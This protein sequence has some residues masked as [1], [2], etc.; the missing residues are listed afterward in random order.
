MR[1]QNEMAT[2]ISID[3]VGATHSLKGLSDAVRGATNAWKAQVAYQNSVGNSLGAAKAKYEGLGNAIDQQKSK[4]NELRNRQ[5]E[6]NVTNTE[7]VEKY[8]KY[9]AEIDKLRSEQT[10]LDTSTKEGKDRFAELSR[11][12]DD[13]REAQSKNTGIT[14][15]DAEQYLKLDKQISQ[16]ENQLRSY[17]AQQKRAAET[18]KYYESGLA[19][20]QKSYK[21]NN[22]VSKSFTERLK[23]EGK[24][25]SA[26]VNEYKGLQNSLKNLKSQYDIQE[27]ELGQIETA[28][29]KT[30]DAYKKQEIRL[31]ETGKSIAETESKAKSMRGEF[32]RLQPTGIDRIDKAVVRTRDTT[33]KLADGAKNAFSRFKNAAIGASIGVATLGAGL[34]K[35]AKEASTLQNTYNENTNLLTTSGEKVKN[36]TKEIA[37]MQLDGRKYSVQYGESQNNIAKGYQELVKRGYDGRQSLGAMKSILQASK[38]SGDDFSDT[39]QVTTSTLEAFGMRTNSIAGMMKNTKQVA[40]ELAMAADATSTDFK[41]LGVGMNYVGTSAHTAGLSLGDTASAMGVLSNSGLEAQQAG[42]GLRKILISLMTPTKG[43]AK[44]FEKYGMSIDDFKDKSGKLKPVGQIFD[45][46]GKK[47]PKGEQANFFHNVFGTTGQNAAAILATNTNE[48]KKVNEQVS[49][50]YKNN[51]V[52][53]LADKNMKST[54]N[55]I[56]R[57]KEAGKAV[58]IE[59]GTA[60]MPALSKAAK[61]MSKAFDSPDVQK[62][63]KSIAKGIGSVANGAADLIAWIGKNTGKVKAFGIAIASAFAFGKTISMFGKLSRT[64]QAFGVA[65]RVAA[66]VSGIG[67]LVTA[68]VAIGA[69]L[70]EL[71][72]HNKK[73]RDFVNGLIKGAKDAYNGVIKWFKNIGK[74]IGK[75]WSSISKGASNVWKSVKKAFEPMTR[76]ISKIWDN[77]KKGASAGWNAIKKVVDFGAKAVKVV[78]LA[79]LVVAAATIVSIWNRIKKPTM[80]VWNWM[81]SFVSGVSK[82]ISRT[83]SNYFNALKQSVSNIWNAIKNITSAIWN[84]IKNIIVNVTKSIWSSVKNTFNSM[85]NGISNIWNSIKDITSNAWNAISGWL[86]K[87]VSAISKSVSGVFNGLKNTLSGILDSI[88]NKWHG[89]WNGMASFFG[90]IWSN[91]KSSAKGG[92]NGVIGW[93][94]GGIGGI[95][96]VIHTFG[97]SKNAISK[98]K[99]LAKGGS[100]K[101]L[102]MVNDGAGEEAIIKNGKAY[103]VTGKN[104]LV[105]FDGN[106]TVIPHEESRMLF[107]NAI[108]HYAKGSDNWFSSLTGWVKDKWEG[109][110]NFIK[111]P[112]KSLTGIMDKA[113]SKVSGSELVT[114]LTPA[115]G[116]GLVNGISS[117][118]K[119]LLESLKKK[120]EEEDFGSAN[121]PGGS[122]VARWTKYIKKAAK[123]M[124]VNLT[125]AGL[126][127]ILNT[128]NHESNGNPTVQ[129]NWDIN[130][131]LGHPSKGL[132]QFIDGTFKHYA[133]K[134]H[135]NILSGYDQLLAM[136][137]DRTWFSDLQWSGGWGPTGGRRFANG[138]IVSSENLYHL[139]EGNKPEYIIPT[140]ISKRPRAWSLLKEV[141]EQFAGDAEMNSQ[142]VSQHDNFDELSKKVDVMIDKFD[143]VLDKMSQVIGGQSIQTQ[144][145]KSAGDPTNRYKNDG[146][147]QSILNFQAH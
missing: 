114:K 87:K 115:L 88:S 56:K 34:I 19:G 31:N 100:T 8:Q 140:D 48:L 25:A 61:A 108:K 52:G 32:N 23:A 96:S 26:T 109:L 3:A 124:K 82:A 134:G 44:A 105:N 5:K 36:V 17:E 59:M 35:G 21:Q 84:P 14:Q 103:K 72:K 94:N 121:N 41:S 133:V 50:A 40:N 68:V 101:G 137:N 79:P 62:G 53:K 70:Y 144:E 97:G 24:S 112:L 126:K 69:A 129:N 132:V 43:G 7:S 98:I 11:Q 139:A 2:R 60:M 30:S 136:F 6:L 47:V 75:V 120:H 10:K 55:S 20:L 147:K 125:S 71:Y 145:I 90:D 9:Q 1:I 38:A 116:H 128:I 64:L 110:T 42:T 80:A 63:L 93:L 16:S 65:A 106:E 111:H 46:I 4:I 81:K 51:Y 33:S 49:G 131:K 135:N 86:G 73:F 28:S 27:K 142:S 85:K 67:L 13:T 66:G 22:E 15:K 104:A 113:I 138:G 58:E 102:A 91:I 127:K 119:K 37:Q 107:G 117:A 83:V 74:G 39:M 12:I 54:Q 92:I 78:A 57:F 130:A 45:E 77:I 143:S 122:G 89:I 99:K 118:F 29:G 141:V 18:V 123:A 146:L 95:N 76:G